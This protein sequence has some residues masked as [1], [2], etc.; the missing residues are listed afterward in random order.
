MVTFIQ[1]SSPQERGGSDLQKQNLK[2]DIEFFEKIAKWCNLSNYCVISAFTEPKRN[3]ITTLLNYTRSH[4]YKTFQI[5]LDKTAS[6][7]I[8]LRIIHSNEDYVRQAK[9]LLKI[10]KKI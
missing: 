10:M 7:N 2:N 6:T 5:K 3:T 1:T 4:N 9:E 8:G